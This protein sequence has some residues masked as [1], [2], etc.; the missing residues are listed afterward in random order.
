M[1]I[2]QAYQIAKVDYESCR[3][4]IERHNFFLHVL[5]E[6]HKAFGH[7]IETIKD[8]VEHEIEKKTNIMKNSKKTIDDVEMNI[9]EF[10][11]LV[12]ATLDKKIWISQR[13]DHGK[14]YY[15]HYQVTGGHKKLDETFEMCAIREAKEEADIDVTTMDFVDSHEGTEP[16]TNGEW[17]A[18]D[19]RSFLR[20]YKLTN[21]L[22]LY[23]SKIVEVLNERFKKNKRKRANGDRNLKKKLKTVNDESVE[24]GDENLEKSKSSD[25]SGIEESIDGDE[26]ITQHETDF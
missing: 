26:N 8:S 14:D 13:I 12:L 21:T 7:Q 11:L 9:R 1:N 24:K 22:Q 3:Y 16:N 17:I 6:M 25:E 4:S 15:M 23:S 5:E 18:V 10:S 20:D 19:F 2:E